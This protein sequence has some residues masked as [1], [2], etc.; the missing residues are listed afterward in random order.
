M[1][2][3]FYGKLRSNVMLM[4]S[5]Q[6][7]R[8]TAFI[9]LS[10]YRK[11]KVASG[12]VICTSCADIWYATRCLGILHR[13]AYTCGWPH[14]FHMYAVVLSCIQCWYHHHH[15]TDSTFS[16]ARRSVLRFPLVSDVKSA[17]DL[18]RNALASKDFIEGET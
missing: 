10:R 16:H 1:L 2:C 3:T 6:V 17:E 8:T 12:V 9:T 13:Y 11:A 4:R 15:C 18:F 7:R 5:H 14:H